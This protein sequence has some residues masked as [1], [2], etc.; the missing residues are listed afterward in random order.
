[1]RVGTGDVFLIPVGGDHA[2]VGQ[3]VEEGSSP[4]EVWIAIF[5]PPA[6]A[7]EAEERFPALTA[8]AP[9]LF[10]Q[11]FDVFLKQG[12]W[13][14]LDKTDVVAPIS[15]PAFKV[16]TAPGVFQVVDHAGV[17][18]RLATTDEIETLPFRSTMSAAGFEHAIA[19]LAGLREWNDFF[20]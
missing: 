16:A 1:M 2:V 8:T 10:G 7:D 19:A 13:P 9:V 15:W 4:T 20:N 18:H 17:V 6:G 12:R 14:L 3:V 11:T 5:W